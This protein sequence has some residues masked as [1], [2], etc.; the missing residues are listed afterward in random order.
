M[1]FIF[2]TTIVFIAELIIVFAILFNLIKFDAYINKTNE[3]LV[4]AKPK[5]EEVMKLVHGISEQILELT[6]I[7]VEK[8][9]KV[10]NELVRKQLESLMSSVLIW[11]INLKAIKYIKKSKFAKFAWKGLTLLQNML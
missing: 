11:C 9:R 2:F 5:I 6:P 3:L 10:R 7:W 8:F 1:V 4:E